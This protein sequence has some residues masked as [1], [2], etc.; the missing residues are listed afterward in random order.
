MC[1][2]F[3]TPTPTAEEAPVPPHYHF[4]LKYIRILPDSPISHFE[5]KFDHD[6]QI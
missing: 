4:L 3:S 6:C 1:S 5:F 2:S